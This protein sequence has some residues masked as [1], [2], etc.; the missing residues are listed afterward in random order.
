MTGMTNF[1]RDLPQ[2][3]DKHE[4]KPDNVEMKPSFHEIDSCEQTKRL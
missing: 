2:N 3:L 4:M 1:V